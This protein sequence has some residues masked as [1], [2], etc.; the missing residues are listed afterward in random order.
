MQQTGSEPPNRNPPE[1]LVT[2]TSHIHKLFRYRC[3]HYIRVFSHIRT[4]YFSEGSVQQHPT[5]YSFRRRVRIKN[6]TEQD[7]PAVRSAVAAA[8][9]AAAAEAA[10]AEVV[11]FCMTCRFVDGQGKRGNVHIPASMSVAFPD[12]VVFGGFI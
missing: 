9:P 7:Q 12:V 3:Q 8:P 5:P 6:N 1:L 2:H 11:R 10:A 4:R